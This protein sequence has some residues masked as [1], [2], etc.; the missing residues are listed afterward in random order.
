MR[1]ISE[2]HHPHSLDEALAL[3]SRHGVVVRALA[4][5]THYRSGTPWPDAVVDLKDL[6]L[7]GVARVDSGFAIGAMTTLRQTAA[8]A[9]LPDALRR[10]AAA[11][12]PRNVQQRATVAGTIA[13]R[14]SGPLL[15]CLLALNAQLR[16][17]PGSRILLLSEYLAGDGGNGDLITSI[18]IPASRACAFAEIRRTPADRPIL[19]VAAG[20]ER[21]F[22][23]IIAAA[24]GAGQPVILLR[25]ASELLE[26][27]PEADLRP[28][29]EAIDENPWSDDGRGTAAYRQAMLP[30]LLK[31]AVAEL[32]A[33]MEVAHAS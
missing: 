13:S 8:S 19:V 7:A 32:V 9:A 4:G 1:I 27:A 15:V 12:A 5:G 17:E 10:A 23:S 6:N 2:Y 14:D 21:P 31:R 18:K 22:A 20:A 24:G 25:E 16:I 26:E 11:Q 33:G 28:L 30:V 29:A 3:L